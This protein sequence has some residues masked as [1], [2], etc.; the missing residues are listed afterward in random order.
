MILSTYIKVSDRDEVEQAESIGLP[1]DNL[2][3]SRME[4]LSIRID[5][6][7]SISPNTV[8]HIGD[9]NVEVDATDVY[10]VSGEQWLIYAQYED[11]MKVWIDG[12]SGSA[13]IVNLEPTMKELLR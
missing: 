8:Q 11:V 1:T 3:S 13:R 2:P 10:M 12:L 6:I 7:E 5:R 9:E 4:R